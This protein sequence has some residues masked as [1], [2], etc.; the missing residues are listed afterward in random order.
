M[1]EVMSCPI[2]KVPCFPPSYAEKALR[3]A[4]G[5]LCEEKGLVMNTARPYS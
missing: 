3:L 2:V 5:F 4:R 1:V